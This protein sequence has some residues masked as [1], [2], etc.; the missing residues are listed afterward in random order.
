MKKASVI[1]AAGLPFPRAASCLTAYADSG[2]EQRTITVNASA[3]ENVIP[4]KAEISF[5]V[6]TS[7][8]T[9]QEAQKE[10]SEIIRKAVAYLTEN[11][12]SEKSIRTSSYNLYPD[13]DYSSNQRKLL[14]YQISC[15]LTVS[16]QNIEDAGKI[17]SECV[18]LGINDV[19]N[20][21]FY[22]SDYD[23]AYEEAMDKALQSAQ[24]K[25]EVLAASAGGSLGQVLRI[26]E[27]WQDTSVRYAN[28]SIMMESASAAKDAGGM[29]MDLMPGETKVTAQLTVTYELK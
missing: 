24:G 18:E 16:D 2:S 28:T 4:D 21:R 5:G 1:L 6:T 17:V 26:Q 12:V 14:G 15:M 29:G 25:A 23:N 10:N 11:G 9:P 8:K 7:A 3:S 27:G 19:N 20:F 13:Y 22:V